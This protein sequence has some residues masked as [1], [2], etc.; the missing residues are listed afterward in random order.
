MSQIVGV[1]HYHSKYKYGKNAKGS[2][3]FL[4][5][6]LSHKEPAYLVASSKKERENHYA[7]VTFLRR[8]ET[9][10]KLPFGQLVRLIGPCNDLN[11]I[12]EA[13]IYKNNLTTVVAKWNRVP[14]E[15]VVPVNRKDITGSYVFSVDPVGCE[16][17][18][19]ALSVV[20]GELSWTVGI[21]IAD[22]STYFEM[23]DIQIKNYGSIYAPHHTYNMIPDNFAKSVC[24]LKPL[25][26]PRFTFSVFIEISSVDC[27]IQKYWFEKTLVRSA[28]AYNYDELQELIDSR[29]LGKDSAESLLYD[30]GKTLG[31]RTAAVYDT[32][33]M[34]ENYMLLAN[35]LVGQYLYQHAPANTTIFRVHEQKQVSVSPNTNV[36]KEIW[37]LLTLLESN[38]ATYAT[39]GTT[40][41][42]SGLCID[43]YTHFTS[44]IRR[45]VDVYIH[46]LLYAVLSG[47]KIPL[48]PDVKMI[49]EH[50]KNVKKAQR[51]FTKLK[52]VVKADKTEQDAV[53][54]YFSVNVT[55]NRMCL[56]FPSLKILHWVKIVDIRFRHLLTFE[57]CDETTLMVSNAVIIK[58]FDTVKVRIIATTYHDE[59]YKKISITIPVIDELIMSKDI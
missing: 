5:K 20:K 11:S 26:E 50:E 36:T 59:I 28:K 19:D 13:I 33:K 52:L 25:E 1:L 22:V 6:P 45:Y 7:I 32:H 2:E 41:Y 12:Y 57:L 53:V 47:T 44:P 54:M 31:G 43:H 42:H 18:D 56:Y 39:E 40:Y 8:D 23:Y 38:A 58:K 27:S 48:L 51:E 4:F 37:N 3:F 15:L 49:N 30:I 35:R 9:K 55:N 34:I 16:D 17:I 10:S 24:S 46:K 29:K 14:K 21:H